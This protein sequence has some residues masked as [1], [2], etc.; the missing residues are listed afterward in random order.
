VKL[1]Q[2]QKIFLKRHGISM[3]EVMDASGMRTT[4]WK[5]LIKD[6]EFVVAI[7]VTE[8]E[9]QGHSMRSHAGH[10]VMCDPAKLAF[11]KRHRS[12][13]EIYIMYSSKSRLIK[14]GVAN[15]AFD[16]ESSLNTMGYGNISDWKLKYSWRIQD[17]GSIEKQVHKVLKNYVVLISHATGNSKSAGEIF[18]CSIKKAKEV[19]ETLV[20]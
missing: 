4:Y 20:K 10:C 19:I 13:G 5:S 17:S 14:V 16:R 15:C 11:Q 18:S 2:E 1:K 8:C 7:G 3:D 9:R 6:S 12:T